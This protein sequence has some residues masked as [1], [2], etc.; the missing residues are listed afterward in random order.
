MAFA[1]SMFLIYTLSLSMELLPA[2]KAGLFNVL[3][4]IGGAC[5]SL[6]GPFIAQAFGFFYVFMAAGVAF[7]LAYVA[8]KTMFTAPRW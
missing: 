8:F 4:G 7:F 6:V 5:G 3:V 2:G 1:Y